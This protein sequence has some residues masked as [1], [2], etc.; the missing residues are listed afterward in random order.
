MANKQESLGIGI[1]G[2]GFMGN[3]YAELVSEYLDDARVV[4][5]SC[6]SRAGDLARKYDATLF[7][8]AQELL[9]CDDVDVVFVAT[10]HAVHAEQGV[11]AAEAGKHVLLEKPMAGSVAECDDI[12][13]A[14]EKHNLKCTIAFS[15]RTRVCNATVQEIVASGRLGRILH[16]RTCQTVP[17]GVP[18]LPQ[19]QMLPENLGTLFGHAI[20]N[21]D[22]VRWLTKQEIASIYAKCR[23]FDPERPTECT[24]DVLMT[25]EDGTTAYLLCCFE[26]PRPGFQR[27]GYAYQ[28]M[29]ERGLVD[30]DAY[31]EARV[32]IDGQP[33]ETVATQPPIDW[34]GKGFLDSV[35]LESYTAQV[36]DLLDSVREDRNPDVTGWDGRQAVAAA[37]AAYESNRTGSEVRLD[38]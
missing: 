38:V 5:V 25:L 32:S 8:S 29:C 26:V 12:I 11:A 33:W 15:Q 6:G 34:Q 2:S 37:L 30:V 31:G 9:A 23:S 35:R 24:S 3:T 7:G 10:P 13:A 36:K 20:H 4:G 18:D 17:G 27:S 22:C 14:C 1:L 21:F 19:W 16:T 28:L